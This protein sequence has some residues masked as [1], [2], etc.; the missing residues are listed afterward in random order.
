MCQ[1]GLVN[2]VL[3]GA[4]LMLVMVFAVAGLAK[5]ADLAGS[6]R[7]VREFG[8]PAALAPLLGTLL[9][10]GELGVAVALIVR[11]SARWGLSERCCCLP[12]S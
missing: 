1:P 10:L 6:R 7:A 2:W 9:P 5:V 8:I 4:R 12:L 11:G 3:L